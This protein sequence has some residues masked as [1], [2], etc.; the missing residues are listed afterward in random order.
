M[1]E[2]PLRFFLDQDVPVSVRG[3]LLSK[4]HQCWT[5]S[6]AKLADAQDD[7]LSVYAMERGAALITL[8]KE[9][10]RRRRQNAIGRHI[11]LH[12]QAPKAPQVL[13]MKLPEVL[14]LLT[15]EHI[16]LT[17]SQDGVRAE[18]SWD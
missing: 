9:F 3:M 6:Q 5:A 10:S 4:G 7:L 13:A 15:R 16:T 17:V 2:G 18:S 1:K 11:W 14:K 12:C 8:D